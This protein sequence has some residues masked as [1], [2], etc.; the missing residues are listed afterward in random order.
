LSLG[1]LAGQRAPES[2]KFPLLAFA[3]VSALALGFCMLRTVAGVYQPL[4]LG[5]ALCLGILVAMET[6]LKEIAA[7][8]LFAT[9]ATMIGLDSGPESG[10]TIAVIKTLLGTW[11]CLLIVVFDLAAYVAYGAKKKWIRVGVRVLGSWIIAISLLVLAFAL[12]K[13]AA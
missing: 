5:L 11:L 6:R 7:I 12:K 3:I 1:L 10:S 2:I 4:L 8:A 9:A 13:K